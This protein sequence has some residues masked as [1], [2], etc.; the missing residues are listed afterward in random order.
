M[1]IVEVVHRAPPTAHRVHPSSPAGLPQPL[2]GRELVVLT[3]LADGVTLEQIARE[4][5]VSRNT[6]KSQVRSLYRKIGVSNRVE[7]LAWAESVGLSET[8]RT[9]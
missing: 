7:A 8:L 2:T 9:A 5:W 6:V 4:L 3:H 1:S